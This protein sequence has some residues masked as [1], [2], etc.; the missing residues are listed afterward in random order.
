MIK[1]ILFNFILI[2][3]FSLVIILFVLS[4]KGIET[5][6]FNK[7]IISKV[8]QIKNISLELNTINFKLDPKELSLFLETKKPKIDY[9]DVSVPTQSI[10][11]YIDFESLLKANLKIKKLVLY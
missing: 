7:L 8:N 10:K 1:K 3:F 6:K 4:T 5:D 2:F 9:L 11:V